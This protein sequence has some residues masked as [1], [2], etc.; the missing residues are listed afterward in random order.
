MT[1]L[2]DKLC[3]ALN[4]LL[5]L[6]P[7]QN[8]FLYQSRQMCGAFQNFLHFYSPERVAESIEPNFQG[9]SELF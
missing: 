8:D 2:L 3:K 7:L 4:L 1:R 9:N 6:R 5:S